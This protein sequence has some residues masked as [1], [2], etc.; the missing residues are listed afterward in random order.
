M[1]ICAPDK[2]GK[3]IKEQFY[4]LLVPGRA[5]QFQIMV[6]SQEESPV[7]NAIN[8]IDLA[9]INQEN[10]IGCKVGPSIISYRGPENRIRYLT[11][12]ASQLGIAPVLQ[13]IESI[14]SR[15]DN[16]DS[17]LD[18][19]G[20]ELIWINDAKESFVL[21]K[22]VEEMEEKF[23]NKFSCIRIVDKGIHSPNNL[24]HAK[25]KKIL[26]GTEPGR[27]AIV[28]GSPTVVEKFSNVLVNDQK[29][30]MD[31]IIPIIVPMSSNP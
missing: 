31:N 4:P 20:I 17:E 12:V 2:D 15:T 25:V 7:I 6:D 28:A 18:I 16:G 29:Y 22:L 8:D 10:L 30:H 26:P 5:N 13:L 11:I 9:D 14:L 3:L 23:A 21:N 24:L 19:D 1:I 27:V